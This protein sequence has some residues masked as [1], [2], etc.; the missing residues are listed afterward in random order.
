MNLEILQEF[1]S[2]I[3]LGICLCVGYI[4]KKWIPDVEN[5]FIPTINAAVSLLLGLWMNSWALTPQVILT[6]L[7]SGLAA[8]GAYEAFRNLLE[9]KKDKET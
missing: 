5:K 9:G 7:F 2:P 1:Y 8:T 4:I 6:S 3:I